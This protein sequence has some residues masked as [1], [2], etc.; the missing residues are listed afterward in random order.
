[1]QSILL[2][3]ALFLSTL[4]GQAQTTCN[5]CTES[6][7]QFDFWVGDWNVYDKSGKKVG[8]N[9]IE[10]LENEC[11][12]SE[13]WKGS[14]GDSGRSYNYYNLADSTWNQVWISSTGNNLVLKGKAGKNKMVLKSKLIENAKGTYYNQ[15]T[16]TKNEDDSVT[17]IWEV[18][19]EHEHPIS[20]SFEGIYKLKP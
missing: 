15:I 11:I 10:K 18:L 12:V 8:E 19:N 5:C 17:Q 9:K 1:M 16:W 7:K 20:T 6:H 4:I 13:N 14:T 3:L 2:T